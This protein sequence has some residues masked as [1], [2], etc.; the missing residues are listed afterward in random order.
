MALL[1]K[2]LALV[3]LSSTR[4]TLEHDYQGAGACRTGL[5]GAA[6]VGGHVVKSSSSAVTNMRDRIGT[7]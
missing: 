7:D 4:K 1:P 6:T 2:D 3:S 5:R